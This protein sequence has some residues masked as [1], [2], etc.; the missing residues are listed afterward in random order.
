MDIDWRSLC[1]KDSEKS[2]YA[3]M[4][5]AV[6]RCVRLHTPKV[7]SYADGTCDRQEEEI[8]CFLFRTSYAY[9][10]ENSD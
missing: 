7:Q 3:I 10:Q 4:E 2:V 6:L 1:I 8:T 9:M 5:T